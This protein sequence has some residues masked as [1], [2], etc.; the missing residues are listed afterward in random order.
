MGPVLG[1]DIGGT[2][3]RIAYAPEGD[4]IT[5][6]E[7][8][9]TPK[10]ASSSREF[11]DDLVA[12][13]VAFRR[14]CCGKV[15]AALGVSVA[16]PVNAARGTVEKPPNLP[17]PTIDLAGPF[18]RS[19]EIPVFLANDCHTG[20]IAEAIAGAGRGIP[21]FVYLTI[22]TGIGGGVFSEGKVL[23]GR[24]GSAVEIGHLH[25]DSLYEMQCGCGYRGHWEGYCSGTHIPVFFI[26]WCSK[27]GLP[28][29]RWADGSAPAV[30]AAAR[31][32]DPVALAFLDCIGEL[33]ARGISDLIVA[34][35]PSHIVLDGTVIVQNQDL[36]LPRILPAIDR[37]LPLPEIVLSPLGGAAPLLGACLLASGA[38]DNISPFT[39]FVG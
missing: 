3:T 33:N 8:F 11:T 27:N 10:G 6:S 1:I 25:I 30:F 17:F 4:S 24:S 19:L 34:Y 5:R 28:V 7:S 18:S 9:P 21:A 23:L 39:P 2:T 22:S 29:P 26:L 35:D 12:A 32:Y 38:A 15:P 20:V 13:L 31:Q 14:S 36:L 16:G 37:Y